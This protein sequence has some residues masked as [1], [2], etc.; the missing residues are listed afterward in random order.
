MEES[1][2]EEVEDESKIC[3]LFWWS[4]RVFGIFGI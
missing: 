4:E 2:A 1:E 3:I